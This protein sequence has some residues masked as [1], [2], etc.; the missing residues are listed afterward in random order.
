VTRP[1]NP[2]P[3]T[4][5]PEAPRPEHRPP[6]EA[7]PVGAAAPPRQGLEF[8]P[9]SGFPLPPAPPAF[10][11]VST[12]L[13]LSR[14]RGRLS[15]LWFLAFGFLAVVVLSALASSNSQA[16][17]EVMRLV[18]AAAMLAVVAALTLASIVLMKRFR[19]EQQQVEAA[20]ELVQLRRWP[21]AGAMLQ[22]I[23]SRPAR[24]LQLRTQSLIYLT[25]VL[26]RYHRF[27]DAIAVQEHLLDNE[28]VEG[29]TAFGLRLGRAMAMLR[30]D[31]LFD[32]DRAISDLRRTAGAA[33][34]ES[35]GLALLEIYRDV[36][37]GH[38]A[39]A[40]ET[41]EKK[42]TALR[43][44]L[45]HRV[46]D[47]YALAARAYDLTGRETEARDAYEKATLLAPPAELSRRY[48]EVQK[49]EGKYD[50]TLAPPEAA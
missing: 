33:G 23:L 24:T 32:A 36:K 8:G 49:L 40:I 9:S 39:E 7:A 27:G 28:L 16:M 10:L 21:E 42:H 34:A 5:R 45:G 19:A 13:D 14:P 31:H 2:H 43:E 1:E 38:P 20:G 17:Q 25:S 46:A 41:F 29:G 37:T 3:E 30:E 50:P 44:Q 12:L 11:D 18:S 22:E 6:P 35:A 15:V 4:P 48:P 26:A 47:A